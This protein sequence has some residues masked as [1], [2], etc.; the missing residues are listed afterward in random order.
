MGFNIGPRVLTATGGSVHRIGQHKVHHFPPQH[1]TDGLVAY[2]DPMQPACWGLQGNTMNDLVGG[3]GPGTWDGDQVA[4]AYN[5]HSIRLGG[6]AS[7]NFSSSSKFPVLTTLTGEMWLNIRGNSGGI[8]G[9][10]VFWQKDGGYSGGMV[11]GLRATDARSFT[12]QAFWGPNSGE[13]D[14]TQSTTTY[15]QDVWYH[16]VVRIDETF[17]L[18]IFVDGADASSTEGHGSNTLNH[19]PPYQVSGGGN[20]GSPFATVNTIQFVTIATTGNATDFGDLTATRYGGGALS[21]S[22][23]GCFVGGVTYPGATRQN[24]I[25]FVN[26]A[27]TGN[28]K[29]FGDMAVVNV[30]SVGTMSDSHGGLS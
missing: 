23:R 12:S 19:K 21:N 3:M 18:R 17:R 28:A 2:F 24:I 1:V 14:M 4:R 22:T 30:N 6:N 16:V 27:T 15:S 11:Y 10:H 26:I 9:Y 13:A 25:D 8:G 20:I 7:C 29:D 5:Q